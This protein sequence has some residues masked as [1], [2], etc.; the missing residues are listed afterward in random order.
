L[1]EVRKV[2]PVGSCAAATDH[3]SAIL[4]NFLAILEKPKVAFRGHNF[5]VKSPTI[6]AEFGIKRSSTA[7]LL[8]V[9]GASIASDGS[10]SD[11]MEKMR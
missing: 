8:A 7:T 1:P 4:E 2:S 5:G 3:L 9:A 6:Q 11:G 10:K